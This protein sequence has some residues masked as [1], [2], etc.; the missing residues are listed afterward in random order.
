MISHSLT[1]N[2]GEWCLDLLLEINQ[3]ILLKQHEAT[4]QIQNTQKYGDTGLLA[5]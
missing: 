3:Q 2:Q 1:S 4:K 5:D